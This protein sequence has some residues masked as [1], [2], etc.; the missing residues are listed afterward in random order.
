VSSGDL[1]DEWDT[2]VDDFENELLVQQGLA[3]STVQSYRSDIEDFVEFC[4]REGITGP[5]AIDAY[6]LTDYLQSCHARELGERTVERRLSTLN[7][8]FQY[9]NREE[10]M[11]AN[12]VE[13]MDRPGFSEE[14]VDFLNRDEVAALLEAP[15]ADDP[16]ERRDR[17]LLECLYATGVRVSE[18][19]SLTTDHIDWDREEIRVTGKG[20][21][22]RL[23]PVATETLD[24]MNRY[25]KDVRTEWDPRSRTDEFFITPEGEPLSR[26]AIWSLVKTYAGR[27]GL[28][29]VS[30]HTLR[31][32]F[33]THLLEGGADLRS[34]Q[35]M[36]GHS[37]VG[38]TAETY[39]HLG[40]Q[41]RDTHDQ[42]HPRGVQ[43]TDS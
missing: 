36:L 15:D 1:S 6:V 2:L 11:S 16:V 20:S 14:V 25:R 28:N 7:Q 33:A 9:L 21:K 22:Q 24:W 43:N 27:A 3:S 18:V 17:A 4:R 35:T 34:L 39:L 10:R 23:I 13:V 5:G 38:T 37:D 31:H 8:F 32:S 19:A 41:I 26:Q 42:Y 12:P 40:Q 30:P 29:D